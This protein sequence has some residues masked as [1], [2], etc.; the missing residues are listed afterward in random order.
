MSWLRRGF[1]NQLM[2]E[3]K[4]CFIL[5]VDCHLMHSFKLHVEWKL[6]DYYHLVDGCLKT[7][8]VSM[9]K[10][11]TA[12]KNRYIQKGYIWTLVENVLFIWNPI[13]LCVLFLSVIILCQHLT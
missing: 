5:M 11:P 12:Q 4:C 9:Q 1:K 3:M 6:E 10:S 8:A 7:M 13:S 2:H